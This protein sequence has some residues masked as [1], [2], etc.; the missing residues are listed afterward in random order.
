[1]ILNLLKQGCIQQAEHV[2]RSVGAA[3][4]AAL[5]HTPVF[6]VVC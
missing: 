2:R 1:M 6:G 5:V 3:V 4:H